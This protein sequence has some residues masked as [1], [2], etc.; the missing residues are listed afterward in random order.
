[1]NNTALI[2]RIN[3]KN[4]ATNISDMVNANTGSQ[5]DINSITAI[6]IGICFIF[7]ED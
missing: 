2:I 7:V 4:P 1:M 3:T 5:E 6:K